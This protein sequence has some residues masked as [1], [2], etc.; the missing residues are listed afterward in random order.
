M[1]PLEI[2]EGIQ[3]DLK[4]KFDNDPTIMRVANM[5]INEF[6]IRDSK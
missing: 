6:K 1:T 2:L 3:K 4:D 5:I